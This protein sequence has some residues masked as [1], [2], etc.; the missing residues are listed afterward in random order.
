MW[1]C[2]KGPTKHGVTLAD[3]QM[4]AMYDHDCAIYS[5]YNSV[6]WLQMEHKALWPQ[7]VPLLLEEVED[8]VKLLEFQSFFW[9]LFY[10]LLLLWG[11]PIKPT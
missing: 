4:R 5:I 3:Q 2:S 9:K 10:F 7:Y 8:K 11:I 6:Q 1:D